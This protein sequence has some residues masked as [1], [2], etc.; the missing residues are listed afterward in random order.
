MCGAEFPADLSARLEAVQEDAEA[1]FEIG[2]DYA[3]K[4]CRELIDAGVPGIHLYVLNKSKAAERILDALDFA[5]T[6]G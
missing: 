5:R 4:Q 1:Q 2:V 6:D 3:I